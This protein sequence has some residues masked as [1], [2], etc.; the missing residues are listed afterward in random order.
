MVVSEIKQ[1]W[2]KKMPNA[3]FSGVM[4]DLFTCGKN[5]QQFGLLNRDFNIRCKQLAMDCTIVEQ[6]LFK[7]WPQK[8]LRNSGIVQGAI[9]VRGSYCGAVIHVIIIKHLHLSLSGLDQ[10]YNGNKQKASCN[11]AQVRSCNYKWK[12]HFGALWLQLLKQTK[13]RASLTR[14]LIKGSHRLEYI[15][16]KETWFDTSMPTISFFM[17]QMLTGT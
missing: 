13:P 11:Q 15:K 10:R 8:V 14:D 12:C 2:L 7:L 16:K 6:H 3:W 9:W 17:K 4:R 5:I 1:T